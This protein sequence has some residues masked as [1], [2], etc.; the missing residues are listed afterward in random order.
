MSTHESGLHG[1]RISPA[2]ELAFPGGDEAGLPIASMTLSAENSSTGSEVT[3][4]MYEHQAVGMRG[5]ARRFTQQPRSDNSS[6]L[7]GGTEQY[8]ELELPTSTVGIL[9]Q[10]RVELN[11]TFTE[12]SGGTDSSTILPSD[13]W[14]SRIELRGGG[15]AGSVLETIRGDVQ[16]L[17]RPY[18]LSEVEAKTKARDM[19]WG[20][21]DADLYLP[22]F[23]VAAGTQASVAASRRYQLDL[24][25]P[26]TDAGV[27]A[28]SLNLASDPI[29][30]RVYFRGTVFAQDQRSTVSTVS[31]SSSRFWIEEHVL[32]GLDAVAAAQVLND[33]PIVYRC[34]SRQEFIRSKGVL[35]D[36]VEQNDLLQ[37]L[38]GLS[39]ALLIYLKENSEASQ[40]SPSASTP[41]GELAEFHQLTAFRLLDWNNGPIIEEE[42]DEINRLSTQAEHLSLP[43]WYNDTATCWYHYLIPFC[44]DFGAALQG[45]HTGGRPMTGAETLYYT[46]TASA[47][48]AAASIHVISYDYASWVCRRDAAPQFLIAR[49]GA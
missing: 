33:H 19:L 8:L 38:H 12:G 13:Q 22:A 6:S 32:N 15:S 5:Y 28:P 45:Q 40:T 43:I 42:T 9:K 26:L 14:I 20:E 35:T 49:V 4:M 3:Y 10:I 29:V 34:L 46:P 44:D 23:S 30:V 17:E 1:K 18:R 47:P 25:T 48:D 2:I 21:N 27:Y 24:V 16:H 36:S 39:A 7:F 11:M 31:V 37:N 41:E